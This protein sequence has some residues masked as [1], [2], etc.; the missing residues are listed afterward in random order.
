MILGAFVVVFYTFL[1]GFAAVCWT[2]FIQGSMMF[3]AVLVVPVT[4]TMT[5]GGPVDVMARL[6]S[7]NPGLF[8]LFGPIS[9]SAAAI[10][11]LSSLG[12]GLGYF[13]QP[14][15]LVRFMAIKE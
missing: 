1:G 15:I 10:V 3:F 9:G 6:T 4:A 5:L 13:G 8:Q 14:H 7:E 12:W 11:L 2:D